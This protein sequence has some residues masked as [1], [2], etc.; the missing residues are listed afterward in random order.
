MTKEDKLKIIAKL[1][2]RTK[3]VFPYLEVTYTDELISIGSPCIA[4]KDISKLRTDKQIAAAM[5]E[6]LTRYLNEREKQ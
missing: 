6:L 4:T 3:A 5:S 2:E 1:A